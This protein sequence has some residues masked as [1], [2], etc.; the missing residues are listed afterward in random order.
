VFFASLVSLLLFGFVQLNQYAD[1]GWY[2]PEAERP[3][4]LK[5]IGTG[6]LPSVD[7][8]EFLN[9]AKSLK[10]SVDSLAEE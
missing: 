5:P 1:H 6:L 10:A 3:A 7:M 8:D 4:Q 9:R 2:N